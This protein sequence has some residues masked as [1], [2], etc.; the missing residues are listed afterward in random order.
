MTEA[1]FY[2]LL[3]KI[4]K[5]Y[6]DPVE[7]YFQVLHWFYKQNLCTHPDLLRIY[8]SLSTVVSNIPALRKRLYYIYEESTGNGRILVSTD[9]AVLF[10]RG[11]V[12]EVVWGG[13]HSRIFNKLD[14]AKA[15]FILK[16]GNYAV[17]GNH[18]ADLPE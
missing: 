6:D 1:E 12:F 11:G 5:P 16:T 15:F 2:A 9:T 14:K 18:F 7:Q 3:D 8:Y 10:K 4:T 13:Q 17:F